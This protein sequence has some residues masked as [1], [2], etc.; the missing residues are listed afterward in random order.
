MIECDRCGEIST[1]PTLVVVEYTTDGD[2][3]R[4]QDYELCCDCTNQIRTDI[5]DLIHSRASVV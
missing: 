3:D 1:T 4:D 2:T 5:M